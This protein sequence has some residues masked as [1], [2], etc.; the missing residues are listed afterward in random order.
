MGVIGVE[1]DAAQ[2][3]DDLDRIAVVV[4]VDCR[5]VAETSTVVCDLAFKS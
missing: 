5:G 1:G 3:V 4:V 2:G